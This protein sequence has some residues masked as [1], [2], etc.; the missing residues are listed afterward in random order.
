MN[1]KVNTVGACRHSANS[2]ARLLS[3]MLL[4]LFFWAEAMP[5]TVFTHPWQGK[6]VAYF[7][8]SITDP[9]NKAASKK[10]WGFL[11][12]WLGQQAYV[13]G[14]SG[15]TWSDIPRQADKCFADHGDSIDA[16]IIF[17]GTNDYNQGIPIGSWYTEKPEQVLFARGK[18][19]ALEDRVQ[20]RPVMSDSTVCG[21]INIALD[22]VKRMYPAKQIV[23]LTPIHRAGFYP[24]DTNWQPT[25]DYT[26]RCGEYIDAYVDVVVQA[27]RVWAVPVIDWNAVGGLFP[28]MDEHAPYFNNKDTDRLH[29]NNSGHQRLARTL[30]YQLAALP[31]T[32]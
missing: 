21:R 30:Y 8:D 6:R 31:C 23:L 11:A 16:V 28:L 9:R 13:Y 1:N 24:N 2:S 22:K 18:P 10:Y 32:F 7:G 15:R 5:Q 20:R 19:K 25:E 4:A 12:D 3:V 27:G 17:M 29:P 14:V 26:N